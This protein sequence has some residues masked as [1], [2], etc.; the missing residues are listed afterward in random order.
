MSRDSVANLASYCALTDSTFLTGAI[1]SAIAGAVQKSVLP[2][3]L[4]RSAPDLSS[5]EASTVTNSPLSILDDP[6]WAMGTLNRKALQ[7]AYGRY[8]KVVLSIAFCI[9][10]VPIL[11][12]ALLRDRELNASQTLVGEYGR[13]NRPLEPSNFAVDETEPVS[14]AG[15]S[16]ALPVEKEAQGTSS[17]SSLDR[18]R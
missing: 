4:A 11:C 17:S 2:I 5:Q 14:G 1:G 6:A 8:W 3:E 18:R 9:S 16:E 10:V 15:S 13:P 7:D 12:T